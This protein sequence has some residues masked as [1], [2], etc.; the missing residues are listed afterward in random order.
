MPIAIV[1]GSG[2]LIGS[3]SVRY[4]AEQGFDVIGID[5]DMRAL[6][7][8]ARG[9]DGAVDRPAC[10]ASSTRFRAR[11][12]RHPRPRR[13]RRAVRRARHGHRARRP[14]RRA[15]VARLGRPRPAHRLH[16]QRQRHAEP[17]GGRARA[18]PRRDVRLHLDEQGLRRPAQ[19]PA[20]GRAR[21]ALGAARGPPV[22]RRHRPR[23]VDRPVH[24]LALRRLQGR[25]RR[26][27]AGVRALLRHAHRLLPRRLP[28]RPPA[29]RRQAARLP[30]LPHA[31]HGDAASRTRSSATRASRSATT[32][33]PHDVVAR[34][35]R[36]P[37]EPAPGRRLQPR[38]RPRQQR[39][40]AR[41]D[42]QV[43]GDRRARARLLALRRGAH[44]RPPV[45]RIATS[46]PSSATTPS[47]S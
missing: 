3:E 35:P 42:R 34:V 28:H 6:L 41:G 30:R 27:G 20:A 4:F 8:R 43:R 23:D 19:R 2:G 21:D 47:G 44:R 18:L 1:T 17:A 22:V 32:S 13:R 12:P 36:L 33:T 45:V 46:A 10:R 25:R 40:D 31:V 24:A 14:H 11:R 37:R 9:L 15:A 29:R 39:L 7:L 38:R 5:N 16:R 26:D